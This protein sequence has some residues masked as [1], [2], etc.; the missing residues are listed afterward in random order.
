MWIAFFKNY[1]IIYLMVDNF[2]QKKQHIQILLK[3]RG[4]KNDNSKY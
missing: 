2:H 4:E 3:K 1:V